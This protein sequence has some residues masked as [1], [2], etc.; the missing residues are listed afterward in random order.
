MGANYTIRLTSGDITG[1]N[2]TIYYNQVISTN[3]A[4]LLVSNS[5]RVITGKRTLSTP[6]INIS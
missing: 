6:T 3:I 1:A 4:T 2:Y 5:R